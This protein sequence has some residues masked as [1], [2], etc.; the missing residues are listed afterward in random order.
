MPPS[1]AAWTSRVDLRFAEDSA[2]E[3]YIMTKSD[4]MIRSIVGLK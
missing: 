1:I 3:L 2:G 4:G